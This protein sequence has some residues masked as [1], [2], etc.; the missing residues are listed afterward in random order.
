MKPMEKIKLI[1]RATALLA[2]LETVSV[3]KRI[4]LLTELTSIVERLGLSE[5]AKGK[6]DDAGAYDAN[7]DPTPAQ[8]EAGNYKK[9]KVKVAGFDIRIENPKGSTRSGTDENGDPWSTTMMNH[10]GDLLGTKGADG[11][12]VDV[13]LGEKDNPEQVFIIDQIDP[14]ARRFDEHKVMLGFDSLQAAKKAY[15]ANYSDNWQGFGAIKAFTLDKFKQWIAGGKTR[16][17]VKYKDGAFQEQ[18]KEMPASKLEPKDYQHLDAVS[19]KAE[20]LKAS[21]EGHSLDSI[22]P[23]FDYWLTVNQA[24]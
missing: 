12:P 22:A 4:P 1:S 15:F 14:E 11:D 5:P 16:S 6:I 18:K 3:I 8:A 24:A 10:Y 23:V 9:G 17:P 13:F 19:L 20:M 7:T 2:E 21:N